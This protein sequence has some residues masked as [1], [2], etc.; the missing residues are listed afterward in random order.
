MRSTG[1]PSPF[2][3][4][5]SAII[6]PHGAGMQETVDLRSPESTKISFA[7]SAFAASFR[8]LINEVMR[9]HAG[10]RTNA[11][12]NEPFADR[13][14][15]IGIYYKRFDHQVRMIGVSKQQSLRREGLHLY[16]NDHLAGSVA[17]IEMVDNLIEHHPE[18]RFTKFF[19]NLRSEIHADQETLRDLI[20]KS[21]AEE[22]AIR[23]AG[24]WLA[25]KFGR[26]KLGDADNTVALLQAL[27][28]LALGITG[29]RLL[30]RSLK[31]ISE[32]FPEFQGTD[33]SALEHRAEDQFKGVENLRLEIAREAFRT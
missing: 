17:A 21:G 33:F 27:E 26:T 19:R 3:A 30:W 16:L 5:Q 28:G 12:V 23:K 9:V 6:I 20:K 32:N 25:E 22:S 10:S 15:A 24:A 14:S 1:K 31:T 13:G 29:K 11:C 8:A 18:D 2:L 4:N 7:A